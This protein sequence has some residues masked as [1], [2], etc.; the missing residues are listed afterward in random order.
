LLTA[1]NLDVSEHSA[2]WF[3]H[4]VWLSYL[5]IQWLIIKCS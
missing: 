5:F 4:V 3:V 2:I 1:K